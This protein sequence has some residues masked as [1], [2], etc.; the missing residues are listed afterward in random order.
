MIDSMGKNAMKLMLK[1]F[2]RFLGISG[3]GWLID[4]SIY[5]FLVFVFH[6]SV[7]QANISSAIPAVSFVFFI[8]TRKVFVK[9]H[10]S[11]PLWLKYLIYVCY[12]I[13]LLLFVSI[14]GQWGYETIM[15]YE[16]FAIFRSYAAIL[17]KSGI[18]G[19]TIICNFFMM[20]F[21]AETI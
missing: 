16:L 11:I 19:I 13:A 18:T 8:S 5:C 4:F 3:V 21:L 6:I 14:I 12:T 10:S 1:K 2:I 17:V 7:F 15:N 9:R 20:K